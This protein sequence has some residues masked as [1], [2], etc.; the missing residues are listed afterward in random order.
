MDPP[1]DNEPE[2]VFIHD[3]AP[4]GAG[5]A[6]A[7]A[8]NEALGLGF[9]IAWNV[10]NLPFF[11]EWKSTASG[12]YVIGLEPANSSVYGRPW[13][14]ERN[15]VHHLAPFA[16]ERNVLT[17]TVLDGQAEIDAALAA[18]EA[19]NHKNKKRRGGIP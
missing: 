1:K 9:K 6:C 15:S 17:F 10:K 13:H 12:D 18:F 2:Y 8:V 14:E 19:F 11:M 3:L 4:D 5:D 16:R 7:I